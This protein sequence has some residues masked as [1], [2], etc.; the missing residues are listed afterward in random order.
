VFTAPSYQEMVDAARKLGDYLAGLV[1]SKRHSPGDDLLTGLLQARDDAG[2]A[3]R[4]EEVTQL[5]LAVV[6]GGYVPAANALAMA[7]LRLAAELDLAADVPVAP[8]AGRGTD[9]LVTLFSTM[10]GK[11]PV[12]GFLH[13][14]ERGSRVRRWAG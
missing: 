13:F 7:L 2:D 10:P 4:P 12:P 8:R 1:E 9:P 6:L 14:P 3:L 11:C 5:V